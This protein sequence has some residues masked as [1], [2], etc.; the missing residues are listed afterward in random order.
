MLKKGKIS[1][2]KWLPEIRAKTNFSA[3][4]IQSLRK[5]KL[6]YFLIS[7]WGCSMD[8]TIVAV[9]ELEDE[10]LHDFKTLG[11]RSV[12]KIT[13]KNEPGEKL[14]LCLQFI[15]KETENSLSNQLVKFYHTSADGNYEP[16][17]PN[18]ESTARLN[19]EAIT[20]VNGQ[21]YI[22]T[23]LPGDYGSSD[24]NRHIHTTVFRARPEAYDIHFEQYS[25]YMGRRFANGSDQ[26]FL[27]DLKR[28]KDNSL[29][30]FLTI[31]IEK[32]TLRK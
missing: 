5:L 3:L 31:E 32:P 20:S 27:A 16:I 1:N 26:H 4:I 30:V 6:V 18:D 29:V 13:D 11:K 21:I 8:Q 14:I 23:I 10:I 15:D 12:L 19:G 22:E 25:T 7:A 9:S 24:N 2:K 17:D 28:A